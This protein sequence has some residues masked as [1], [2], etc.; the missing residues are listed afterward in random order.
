M[1]RKTALLVVALCLAMLAGAASSAFA[2]ETQL[3]FLYFK[4][5]KSL[6][7]DAVWKGIDDYAWCRKSGNVKGFPAD[8]VEMKKT[9][10]KS[11]V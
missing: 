6:K 11:V 7:C 5:G 9:D 4:N 1:E 8:D 2:D 3:N 10:R